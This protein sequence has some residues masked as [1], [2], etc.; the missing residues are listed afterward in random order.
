MLIS[1]DLA[2]L[3]DLI[4]LTAVFKMFKH[5]SRYASNIFFVKVFLQPFRRTAHPH[6][7]SA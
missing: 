3:Y 4:D 1:P 5:Q 7:K 2:T 6:D